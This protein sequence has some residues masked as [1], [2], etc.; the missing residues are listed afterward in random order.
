MVF[1]LN[2]WRQLV[3]WC[4]SIG[5][6][7]AFI[8]KLI[9]ALSRPC[10]AALS[11]AVAP[12]RWDAPPVGHKTFQTRDLN[13]MIYWNWWARWMKIKVTHFEQ[14]KRYMQDFQLSNSMFH[15]WL[16]NTCVIY[17]QGCAF[18]RK[19]DL[20]WQIFLPAPARVQ[21]VKQTLPASIFPSA[22][23]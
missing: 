4:L 2:L 3:N 12:C 7:L 22:K 15:L 19:N 18:Q 1:M 6:H 11:T 13:I 21:S 20:M 14:G 16:N 9:P 5:C 8:P 10:I 17:K 23:M